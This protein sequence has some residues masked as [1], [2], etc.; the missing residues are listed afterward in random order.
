M[1]HPE[2]VN[3]TPFAFA[4][5]FVADEELRPVL[6]L[7]VKA[8]FVVRPDGSTRLAEQQEAVEL[9]GTYFGEPG[10]SSVRREP[11]VAFIKPGTDCVLQGHA[12]APR[13]SPMIDVGFR[14]GELTKVARVFGDRRWEPGLLG[15]KA[16]PPKPFERLPLLWERAFGGWDRTPAKEEH[17]QRELQNPLGVGFT[18]K[19]GTL[20]PG[21]ALPNIEDPRALL[22]SQ[23][24]RVAPV[25]FGFTGG[26]WQPRAKFAGTFDAAW[27]QQRAPRL[28]KDFDRRFFLAAAPGLSSSAH[29]RG[30]EPVVVLG[31]TPEGRWEFSLPGLEPPRGDLTL[32]DGTPR[33][34]E[35]RLDT[36]IVDADRRQLVLLWRAFTTL[37][38][39][40]HDVRALSI[41]AASVPA[42]A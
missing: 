3:R 1:G 22:T 24:N 11:E 33:Q 28:P 40:P 20:Q 16:S 21:A 38:H 42:S 30:D 31:A 5:L 14:V 2:I 17:H 41:T 27:E 12:I 39:G 10:L 13:P 7:V 15:S 35:A 19:K 25:G 32:R 6:A 37:H 4:P 18:T 9:A 26:D 34:L 23:G 8:T 36:V 29:L